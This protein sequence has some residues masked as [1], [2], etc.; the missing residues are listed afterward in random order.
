MNPINGLFV[1]SGVVPLSRGLTWSSAALRSSIDAT[2]IAADSDK[3]SRDV[4]TRVLKDLT[5]DTFEAALWSAWCV[6][7]AWCEGENDS[8][9][10]GLLLVPGLLDCGEVLVPALLILATPGKRAGGGSAR[11]LRLDGEPNGRMPARGGPAQES[12]SQAATCSRQ[13]CLS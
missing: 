7:S 2:S 5:R 9:V 1:R 11:L 4:G 13:A 10:P 3:S 12:S 8:E 6:W